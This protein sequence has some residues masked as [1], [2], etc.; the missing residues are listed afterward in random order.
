M[1]ILDEQEPKS[2]SLIRRAEVINFDV[3]SYISRRIGFSLPGAPND[4][5]EPGD[6]TVYSDGGYRHY[7]A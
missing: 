4:L 2:D 5:M 1:D 3:L 6:Y 7:I